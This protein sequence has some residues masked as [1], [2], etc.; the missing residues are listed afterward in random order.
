M[1]NF[2]FLKRIYNSVM[3]KEYNKMTNQTSWYAIGYLAIFEIIFTIAI[4]ILVAK[5]FFTASFIDIYKYAESFLVDFFDNSV[6]LTFDTILIL[7]AL[8][9][10]YQILKKD[11]KKYS[12]M[13]CLATY[14]ST[15][16]IIIKYIVFIYNY[17]QN[18]NI[19]YFYFI[20]IGIVL[21]YF[22]F[23]YKKAIDI[24]K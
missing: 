6:S 18:K 16:A 7:S 20:Y 2:A 21:S 22:L 14:S 8:A 17:T 1:D 11:K 9:Y 10:L 12:K 4:S 19:E 5:N 13:F 24:K 15:L 3:C 23:N